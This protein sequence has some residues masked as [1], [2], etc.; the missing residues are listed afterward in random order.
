MWILDAGAGLPLWRHRDAPDGPG[1]ATLAFSTRRG[2]GSAPPCDSLNLG[3]STGDRAEAVAENRRRLLEALDLAPARLATAGQIHGAAVS[4]ADAPGHYP[5][6]DILVTR[7]PGLAL[8]ISGADCLPILLVAPG[9]IAAAHAGWRG[10]AAGAPRAALRALCGAASVEPP[11]VRAHFGPC[12]R[13]CCYEVGAEVAER[14]PAATRSRVDGGWRLDL[15]AAA[16]LQLLEAGVP[17]GAV[18][19]IG[20]C[21]SCHPEL[22]FSYRRDAGRTG[23]LWGVAALRG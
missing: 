5:D 11:R 1:P 14:F 6:C 15:A 2:G 9:A 4:T 16:R 13:P 12:I 21:T 3:R 10:V 7:A 17:E 23:R 19:D 22:Y 18:A 8:A 20:A